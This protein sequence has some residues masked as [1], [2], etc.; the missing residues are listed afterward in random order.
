MKSIIKTSLVLIIVMLFAACNNSDNTENVNSEQDKN[1]NEKVY[2]VKVQ[3][4]EKQ[5]ITRTLEYT[6]NL[7]AFK[8]INY[9]QC[10]GKVVKS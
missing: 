4:I 8:E 10:R 6:A 5:K 3:K 7:M 2:P 9:A 1:V